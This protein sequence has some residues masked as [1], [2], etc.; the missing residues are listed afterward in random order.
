MCRKP[1]RFKCSGLAAVA[2]IAE[3]RAQKLIES[4]NDKELLQGL[5]HVRLTDRVDFRLRDG[6]M[7]KSVDALSTGQKCA[8]TMPIG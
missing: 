7:D 1:W 2:D 3:D 4:L 5:A 8:V 6:S